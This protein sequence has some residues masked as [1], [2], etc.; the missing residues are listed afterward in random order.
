VDKTCKSNAYHR[1]AIFGGR[2]G[3]RVRN[4]WIICLEVRNN[5]AKAGLMPDVDGSLKLGT[6][7]GLALPDESAAYQLVGGVMAHQG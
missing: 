5:S 2:S 1:V 4:T 7:K 3:A 6:R